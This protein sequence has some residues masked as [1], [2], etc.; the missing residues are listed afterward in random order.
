MAEYA[1]SDDITLTMKNNT[2]YRVEIS[3]NNY[4]Y[5]VDG[6]K[7][8]EIFSRDPK[9]FPK[10]QRNTYPGETAEGMLQGVKSDYHLEKGHYVL[11]FSV[12]LTKPETGISPSVTVQTEF[13]VE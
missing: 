5:R 4:L 3:D 7:L 11:A 1:A 12:K 13:D 10:E 9:L 6:K 8:T 2:S